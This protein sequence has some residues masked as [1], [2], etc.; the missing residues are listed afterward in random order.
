MSLKEEFKFSSGFL[1]GFGIFYS[2]ITASLCLEFGVT[3][4]R[5]DNI[6]PKILLIFIMVSNFLYLL[7]ISVFPRKQLAIKAFI[8]LIVGSSVLM[9]GKAIVEKINITTIACSSLIFVISF[10]LQSLGYI[11]LL[12]RKEKL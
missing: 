3:I 6:W 4:F 7:T 10:L 11:G 8:C 2:L 12:I 1:R 5:S 9:I